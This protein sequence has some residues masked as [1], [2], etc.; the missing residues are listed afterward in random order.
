MREFVAAIYARYSS[1]KQRDASIEDQVSRCRE[2]AA[3]EG[4]VVPGHL[5]FADRAVSG[6]SIMR[7]GFEDLMAL[8]TAKPPR[9]DVILVEDLSRIS[10]SIA[11]SL[12][13][14]ESLRF[15]GVVLVTV[16]DGMKTT[17]H[18]A[19]LPFAF[20]AIMAETFLDD[21][22]DKTLRGLEGRA[23]A[24]YSTGALPH[25]YRGVPDSGPDGR[26]IGK[27]IEINE[28]AAEVVRG[29]F[30][31][32]LAGS[33][34]NQIAHRLNAQ[35]VRPPRA[36]SRHRRQGWA[37]STVRAILHN[38]KYAG[39]WAYKQRQWVKEPGTPRRVP[40]PRPANEV[41]EF[42]RPD[43][44][45]L[46]DDVW[47]ATQ[48]RLA[49]TRTRYTRNEDGSPKG[50]GLGGRGEK[51]LLSGLLHCDACG[52]PLVIYGGSG[53]RFYRC[54]DRVNRGTCKNRLGVREEE[55]RRL[56]VDG[57]KA[58]LTSIPII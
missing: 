8:A 44:A 17:A 52:A 15:A 30:D 37:A 49:D 10:R 34:L 5:V 43:L 22:R 48:R 4:L 38:E 14:M 27:R 13:V 12:R 35:G 53:R 58:Q 18:G 9:F 40:R 2:Y 20:K 39:R 42:V 46:S 33:S 31:E 56:V 26:E 3:R 50:R 57:V 36:G 54:A 47:V 11:D 19:K 32:Y 41:M 24:G 28:S 7:S 25:G 16:A 21:L 45:I 1:D 51:Y 29:I 55:I 23:R 6:A